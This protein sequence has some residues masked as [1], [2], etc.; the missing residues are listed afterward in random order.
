MTPARISTRTPFRDPYAMFTRTLKF[1]RDEKKQEQE[2]KELE[3]KQKSMSNKNCCNF[4][5]KLDNDKGELDPKYFVENIGDYDANPNSIKTHIKNGKPRVTIKYPSVVGKTGKKGWV[6]IEGIYVSSLFGFFIT[7][8]NG[9]R[10][11]ENLGENAVLLLKNALKSANIRLY[12]IVNENDKDTADYWLV[13]HE[14]GYVDDVY[15]E[16]IPVEER[17]KA[18]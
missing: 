10:V 12:V 8:V 15:G 2:Q 5:S 14:R 3:S 4:S 9:E 16:E 11:N 13:L 1:Y 18:R 17:P 6:V 7:D